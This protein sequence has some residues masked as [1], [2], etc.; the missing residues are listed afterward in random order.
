MAWR[1]RAQ[2]HDESGDLADSEGERH[3]VGSEGE[4]RHRA[5]SEAEERH[6]GGQARGCWGS[7]GLRRRPGIVERSGMVVGVLGTVRA[8]KEM[9]GMVVG[10]LEIL[11][12]NTHM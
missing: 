6:G 9:G 5:G 8:Q 1:T 11:S 4:Q 10:L 3:Q 2:F 7:C 12:V